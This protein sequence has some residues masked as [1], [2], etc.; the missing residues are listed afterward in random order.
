[1]K[2]HEYF[3]QYGKVV[4]LVVN[5]SH[6]YQGVSVSCYVTYAKPEDAFR[7]ID[8]VDGAELNGRILHASF[9]TTKYCSNFMKARPCNNPECMYLHELGDDRD[10]F[11]K[12][13]MQVSKHIIRNQEQAEQIITLLASPHCPKPPRKVG[14]VPRIPPPREDWSGM[15]GRHNSATFGVHGM[16]DSSNWKTQSLNLPVSHDQSHH[17]SHQPS[18]NWKTQSQSISAPKGHRGGPS[19]APRYADESDE[20]P[21]VPQPAAKKAGRQVANNSHVQFDS[22]VH[23]SSVASQGSAPNGKAVWK[24]KSQ[25]AKPTAPPSMDDSDFPLPSQAAVAVTTAAKP[26]PRNHPAAQP[27]QPAQ[28]SPP[29]SDS[30]TSL[31]KSSG[32]AWKVVPPPAPVSIQ[33]E[34]QKS[35]ELK[36]QQEA[37][38]SRTPTKQAPGSVLPSSASWASR[39]GGKGGK[40]EDYTDDESTSP[41]RDQEQHAPR[42]PGANKD[43]PHDAHMNV[44]GP[45]GMLPPIPGL[46]V[47]DP[48]LLAASPELLAEWLRVATDLLRKEMPEDTDLAAA[49]LAAAMPPLGNAAHLGV[50]ASPLTGKP[51]SRFQFARAPGQDNRPLEAGDDDKRNSLRAL[52]PN[53]SIKFSENAEQQKHQAAAA[54]GGV[55]PPGS[56]KQ[57]PGL[58]ALGAP[59]QP[60]LWTNQPVHPQ[61]WRQDPRFAGGQ[62]VRPPTEGFVQPPPVASQP[63]IWGP[64]L[65]DQALFQLLAMPQNPPYMGWAGPPGFQP[66]PSNP[67]HGNKK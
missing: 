40:G 65:S 4:K 8:A 60:L 61:V 44:P 14:A 20:Q 42:Q 32:G 23:H 56:I 48:A 17:Q 27:S 15:I 47:I 57:P 39:N 12:E 43:I 28:P 64:N 66:P 10:S 29:E 24:T 7:C 19:P 21:V 67:P 3:G 53:V 51:N 11:T 49:V 38:S 1:L 41:P 50:P 5:R 16:D 18:S 6:V 33:A 34:I 36:K 55:P 52:L 58:Q 46:P 35:E 9:G 2:R 45:F 54:S 22:E 25:P 30:Q 31:S 62:N 13:D 59:A 26:A 37:K 63:A